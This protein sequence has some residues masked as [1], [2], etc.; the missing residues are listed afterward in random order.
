VEVLEE[1]KKLTGDVI[2]TTQ[3][4]PD[5]ENE[6][7]RSLK[8][9][10]WSSVKESGGNIKVTDVMNVGEKTRERFAEDGFWSPSDFYNAYKKGYYKEL[11]A[12]AKE[13]RGKFDTIAGLVTLAPGASSLSR[14]DVIKKLQD[15]YKEG[16]KPF[17]ERRAREIERYLKKLK[18][19]GRVPVTISLVEEGEQLTHEKAEEYIEEETMKDVSGRKLPVIMSQ[20]KVIT[21][22]P[23]IVNK[24]QSTVLDRG[25]RDAMTGLQ[26]NKITTLTAFKSFVDTVVKRFPALYDENVDP[27][28]KKRLSELK[29]EFIKESIDGFVNNGTF[30]DDAD[31]GFKRPSDEAMAN[32]LLT[33]KRATAVIGHTN[34]FKIAS[35]AKPTKSVN[36]GD[37]IGGLLLFDDYGPSS[38]VQPIRLTGHMLVEKPDDISKLVEVLGTNPKNGFLPRGFEHVDDLVK[39]LMY[40]FVVMARYPPVL[41]AHTPRVKEINRTPDGYVIKTTGK[42]KVLD[43][44]ASLWVAK[45]GLS[46]N[47]LEN[48]KSEAI[49][50]KARET[51]GK[52]LEDLTPEERRR[53]RV[54]ED[55]FP[56][57]WGAQYEYGGSLCIV[58]PKDTKMYRRLN[59]LKKDVKNFTVMEIGFDPKKKDE[60]KMSYEEHIVDNIDYKRNNMKDILDKEID[61]DMKK[62]EDNIGRSIGTVN[63][64]TKPNCLVIPPVKKN[65]IKIVKSDE[66][67]FVEKKIEKTM[68]KCDALQGKDRNKCYAATMKITQN[69]SEGIDP[70][71]YEAIRASKSDDDKTKEKVTAEN[72]A[73]IERRMR[74]GEWLEK[75][76]DQGN[77]MDIFPTR[78]E[79]S[80]VLD[81]TKLLGKIPLDISKWL[82]LSNF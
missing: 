80:D 25:L 74:T 65:E 62:V 38:G 79:R 64:R 39:S 33:Q 16:A 44:S 72:L 57:I 8:R 60:A 63:T 9:S 1:K 41:S 52:E 68:A 56:D 17:K 43:A 37:P 20:N 50:T 47:I 73:S 23:A 22:M 70:S 5:E 61:R 46:R 82:F 48:I 36:A 53:L 13:T 15:H 31:F 18:I 30:I 14:D 2:A 58:D 21:G 34:N 67:Q 27:A 49:K 54:E 28:N 76:D 35:I 77:L 75:R 42:N 78:A 71:I 55:L 4:E 40:T 26:D 7:E 3:A 51:F 29:K 69:F 6:I 32:Y 12:L 19:N 24:A 10:T 45:E 81:A 59:A 11:A 66:S